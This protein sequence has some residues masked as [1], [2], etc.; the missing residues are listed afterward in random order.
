M[1]SEFCPSRTGIQK[2]ICF[3]FLTSLPR[4][5]AGPYKVNAES[6]YRRLSTTIQITFYFRRQPTIPDISRLLALNAPELRDI[7]AVVQYA[8]IWMSHTIG[9]VPSRV[10]SLENVQTDTITFLLA[11]LKE[12]VPDYLLLYLGSRGMTDR[13]KQELIGDGCT[14]APALFELLAVAREEGNSGRAQ[15]ALLALMQSQCAPNAALLEAILATQGA[16]WHSLSSGH[17]GLGL[18]DR[19]LTVKYFCLVRLVE[20]VRSAGEAVPPGFWSCLIRLEFLLSLQIVYQRFSMLTEHFNRQWGECVNA[21][22][23]HDVFA[24]RLKSCR[25]KTS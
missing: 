13:L 1:T 16:P 23:P 6:L 4:L 21:A 22:R 17:N 10:G 19:E 7:V 24:V 8:A 20:A 5:T 3:L 11:Y 2:L 15:F 9:K 14:P 25:K 12:K 18:V